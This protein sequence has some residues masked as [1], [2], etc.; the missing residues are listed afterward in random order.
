MSSSNYR[1][2]LNVQDE[3]SQVSLPVRLGDT[4]RKLY[5][6]IADGGKPLT[7]E[8]G[9]LAV[10][11]GKKEDGK[12]IVSSCEIGKDSSIVY[13]F[14]NQ[15]T[16]CPGI[17]DC[18]I[19]LYDPNGKPLASPRFVMVVDERVIV[20]GE[21]TS[22]YWVTLLDEFN[23]TE[24]QRRNAEALRVTAEEG[25]ASAEANRAE[26]EL[27]REVAEDL[28]QSTFE[29]NEI[30]R[31][32]DFDGNE[33]LRQ[34]TFEN[35]ES[36][37]E[38]EYRSAYD[39]HELSRQSNFERNEF[40]RQSDFEIN[41]ST[42]QSE[43]E[44]AES[45]RQST[46]DINEAS[47]ASAEASRVTAEKSRVYAETSRANNEGSRINAE[48]WRVKDENSRNTYEQARRDAEKTRLAN[49]EARISAETVRLASEDVR[50]ANE[51]ARIEAEAI[52]EANAQLYGNAFR[53][54]ASGEI[55]RVDDVSPIVHDVKCRVI[56]NVNPT[57]VTVTRCGKNLINHNI[58]SSSSALNGVTVTR[59]DDTIT[60]NGTLTATSVLCNTAFCIKGD[61]N[62]YT[63][64]IKYVSGSV[65]GTASACVG[66]S[67]SP[68][69][70]RQGWIALTMHNN[71]NSITSQSPNQFIKDFWIYAMAGTIFN[72][73]TI[74]VQLEYGSSFTEYEKYESKSC[75]PLSDGT[76]EGIKSVAPTMTLL[77][78]TE[79]VV[80]EIEYNQD[81]NVLKKTIKECLDAIIEIQNRLIGGTSQ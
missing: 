19:R 71:D 68:N 1:F 66:T 53:G 2:T 77:T 33:H 43:F 8:N 23:G 27:S 7:I 63:L 72:N 11:V 46:F 26:A 14:T 35:N 12:A 55:I 44:S 45:T 80:I 54:S 42:R 31:Q 74:K 59:T 5:I 32:S 6:T 47:R 48:E 67:V 34:E 40:V 64:S 60:L 78:D 58:M 9:S 25:R 73:F 56:G 49:E 24:A 52:R 15:T 38:Q 81:V 37:R 21:I 39:A 4:D 29:S 17:V 62:K 30:T 79:N 61:M 28:R 16:S 36:S 13:D 57:T 3:Q 50:I 22:E 51:N 69:E 10:F 75:V 76:V 20:D 70:Q 65:E 18:E 41:E